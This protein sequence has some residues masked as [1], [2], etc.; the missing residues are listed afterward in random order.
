MTLNKEELFELNELLR[1]E[2][3]DLPSFRKEVG[4]SGNNYSWLQKNILV[5][6]PKTSTR[7]RELLKLN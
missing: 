6:N 5:K 4:A 3:L 2:K 7:L 1:K